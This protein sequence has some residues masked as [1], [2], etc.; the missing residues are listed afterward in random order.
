MPRNNSGLMGSTYVDPRMILTPQLQAQGRINQQITD[1]NLRSRTENEQA[2]RRQYEAFNE[3]NRMQFPGG[4]TQWGNMAGA[5][6]APGIGS[7]VNVQ[8]ERLKQQQM[9]GGSAAPRMMQIGG[10]NSGIGAG[11]NRSPLA[12]S[13]EDHFASRFSGGT[14][15]PMQAMGVNGQAKAQMSRFGAGKQAALKGQS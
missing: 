12:Q 11:V 3:L 14:G 9:G 7:I 1:S 10:G 5:Y 6:K 15:Q 2:V 13:V 4:G 8:A